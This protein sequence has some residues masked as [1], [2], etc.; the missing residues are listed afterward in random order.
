MFLQVSDLLIMYPTELCSLQV[1][2]PLQHSTSSCDIPTILPLNNNIEELVES[3]AALPPLVLKQGR[4]ESRP[5]TVPRS[6]GSAPVVPIIGVTE[7]HALT[8]EQTD[9]DDDDEDL[10]DSDDDNASVAYTCLEDGEL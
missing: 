9:D 3:R 7:P 5:H 10:I 8:D 6:K 4:R 2:S 1:V